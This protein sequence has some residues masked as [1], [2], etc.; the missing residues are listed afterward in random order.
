MDMLGVSPKAHPGEAHLLLCQIHPFDSLTLRVLNLCP[1]PSLR[2]AHLLHVQEETDRGQ[3]DGTLPWLPEM[4]LTQSLLV[5][6]DYHGPPPL[7]L[8]LTSMGLVLWGSGYRGPREPVVLIQ[9]PL[10]SLVSVA[11]LTRPPWLCTASPADRT[12]R[13]IGRYRPGVASPLPCVLP[14]AG[15]QEG[16]PGGSEGEQPEL[17]RAG[18]ESAGRGQAEGEGRHSRPPRS[19]Q[20][21]R[22]RRRR[23]VSP[24]IQLTCA[25]TAFN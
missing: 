9:F 22:P 20:E 4:I 15:H 18:E 19:R 5:A 6:H 1:P 21:D 3:E 14:P 11:S 7:F 25:L 16:G 13:F 8:P 2:R 12:A 17:L 10:L 24:T 23:P